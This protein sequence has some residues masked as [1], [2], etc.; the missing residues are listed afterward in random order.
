VLFITPQACKGSGTVGPPFPAIAA[1]KKQMVYARL[2]E[3]QLSVT[4]VA[5]KVPV[6]FFRWESKGK[7]ILRPGDPDENDLFHVYKY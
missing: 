5:A 4:V 7:Y 1:G 3:L 2:L 6:I